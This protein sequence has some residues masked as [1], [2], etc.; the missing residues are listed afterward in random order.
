MWSLGGVCLWIEGCG[1]ED[2]S[3]AIDGKNGKARRG[4]KKVGLDVE[5][6][7]HVIRFNQD[8]DH[9]FKVKPL[10]YGIN[11][12]ALVTYGRC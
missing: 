6:L 2:V 3:E 9:C 5:V 4:R 1:L 10:A 12:T 7:F 11:F 8:A